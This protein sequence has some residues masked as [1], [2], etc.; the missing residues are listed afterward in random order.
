MRAV[1]EINDSLGFAAL[2]G[3]LR[4][5]KESIFAGWNNLQVIFIAEAEVQEMLRTYDFGRGISRDIEVFYLLLQEEL[6]DKTKK[7]SF[8]ME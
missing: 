6:Q 8:R 4:I 7:E 1:L 2:T 5:S 3:G